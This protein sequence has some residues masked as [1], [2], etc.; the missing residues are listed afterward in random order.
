[1]QEPEPVAPTVTVMKRNLSNDSLAHQVNIA[2]SEHPDVNRQTSIR[3][4]AQGH[5]IVLLGQSPQPDLS[6]DAEHIANSLPSTDQVLNYVTIQKP[7]NSTS[8]T[9]D[10]AL[11][12]KIQRTLR[13]QNLLQS[14]QI[15][16][17]EDQVIYF[18]GNNIF[19]NYE[20]V[21]QAILSINP[22]AT[23]IPISLP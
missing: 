23:I 4:I 17:T 3:V 7:L 9:Q 18:V 21:E 19:E 20:S 13:N 2:I 5:N 8:R 22:S 1:M 15:V 16:T 14:G 6:N 11:N 10:L 12:T